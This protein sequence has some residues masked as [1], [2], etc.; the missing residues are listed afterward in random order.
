[1]SKPTS[2]DPKNAVNDEDV[3]DE[4]LVLILTTE[5]TKPIPVPTGEP[6]TKDQ[7]SAEPKE[8][9]DTDLVPSAECARR[10]RTNTY[11]RGPCSRNLTKMNKVEKSNK[12]SVYLVISIP[13]I[14]YGLYRAV[15]I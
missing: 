8:K 14:S 12:L 13:I 10:S 3:S 4:K 7:T 2:S 15:F 11:N 6:E 5:C 1:M 9:S